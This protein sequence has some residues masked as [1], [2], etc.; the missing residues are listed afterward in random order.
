MRSR[1]L[2]LL[3]RQRDQRHEARGDQPL[4][5]LNELLGQFGDARVRVRS[6]QFSTSCDP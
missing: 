3:I 5:D 4:L 2:S 1:S 6:E